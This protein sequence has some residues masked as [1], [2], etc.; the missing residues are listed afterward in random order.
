VKKVKKSLPKKIKNSSHE[1]FL[2]RLKKA[3]PQTPE[4]IEA[5]KK[6]LEE[7]GAGGPIGIWFDPNNG[8]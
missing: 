7:L 6:I 1:A 8:E 2:R 4:Q 5:T 3:K